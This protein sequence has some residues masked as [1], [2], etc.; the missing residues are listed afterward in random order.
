M[1]AGKLLGF[2]AWSREPGF[3]NHALFITRK[4]FIL[5]SSWEMSLT[6]GY[7][8]VRTEQGRAEFVFRLVTAN[9][10]ELHDSVADTL[11][12]GYE[13]HSTLV[14]GA[15]LLHESLSPKHQIF[16]GH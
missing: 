15:A 1:C 14:G 5:A 13:C 3:G 16:P 11:P 4:L 6:L 8:N 12:S 10:S 7:S 9:P 2:Q